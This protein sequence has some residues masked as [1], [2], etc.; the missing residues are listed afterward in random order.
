MIMAKRMFPAI[1][2]QLSAKSFFVSADSCLLTAVFYLSPGCFS[3]SFDRMMLARAMML[4]IKRSHIIVLYADG[5]YMPCVLPALSRI[6][7]ING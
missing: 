7:P 2:F 3:V 1:S 5:G 6:Y 4:V